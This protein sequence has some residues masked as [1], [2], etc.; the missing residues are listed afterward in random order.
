MRFVFH[1]S[2]I[3]SAIAIPP[4]SPTSPP[5]AYR[6]TRRG[7]FVGSPAQAS[8]WVSIAAAMASIWAGVLVTL[9]CVESNPPA[10][11]SITYDF[12]RTRSGPE[13]ATRLLPPATMKRRPCPPPYWGTPGRPTHASYPL[14]S[15]S[16]YGRV[17]YPLWPHFVPHEFWIRKPT[18]LYPAIRNAWPPISAAGP[19]MTQFVRPRIRL[20][21]GVRQPSWIAADAAIAPSSVIAD[22]MSSIRLELTR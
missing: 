21:F 7:G 15:Q 17:A 5:W 2:I 6:T 19:S 14:S 10:V 18:S 12:R 16:S 20:D 22:C 9:P 4:A 8:C 11:T 1:Q 3:R 13:A